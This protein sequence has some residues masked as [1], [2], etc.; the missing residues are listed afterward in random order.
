MRL[1]IFFTWSV[2]NLKHAPAQTPSYEIIWDVLV[3]KSTVKLISF[4]VDLKIHWI[5]STGKEGQ[6]VRLKW[7]GSLTPLYTGTYTGALCR[8]NNNMEFCL[9]LYSIIHFNKKVFIV[10]FHSNNHS[11]EFSNSDYR[12][13]LLWFS[14]EW[15]PIIQHIQLSDLS[16]I[17]LQCRRNVRP[18]QKATIHRHEA[19]SIH[20]LITNNQFKLT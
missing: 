11:E 8:Q 15:Q 10:D 1:F 3:F 5:F 16:T 18:I 14:S 4:C 13:G 9:L 7:D 2:L 12:Y 17:Q 20:H 19:F 6:L